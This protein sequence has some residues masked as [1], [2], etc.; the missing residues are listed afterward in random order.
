MIHHMDAWQWDRYQI[1]RWIAKKF[2][3]LRE[4]IAQFFNA[5]VDA[6]SNKLVLEASVDLK[7]GSDFTIFQRFMRNLEI[8]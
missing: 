8:F 3:E 5:C 2:N 4:Y 1:I 6:N 7:S